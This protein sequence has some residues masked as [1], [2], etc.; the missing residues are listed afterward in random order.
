MRIFNHRDTWKDYLTLQSVNPIIKIL[1]ISDFFVLSAFGL[2]GPIFAIF[3]NDNIIGGTIEVIG[4]AEAIFL[5]SKG[6]LQI[7]VASY[8]DKKRG[9]RDDFFALFIGSIIYSLIPVFYLIIDQP[10]QL[11]LVQI[12]YGIATA[13]TLPSWYALFTRHVDKNHEGIEWG[14]Y[15]TYTEF[16]GA[17]AASV[18]GYLAYHFGFNNLFIIVTVVSLVGVMF[19]SGMYK[20]LKKKLPLIG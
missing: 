19:L 17:L 16:G 18:G 14:I 4:I 2:F 8:I 3:I 11:F 15:R 1:I 6:A 7:P 12:V 5:F 10:W 13:F 20:Y 9:E